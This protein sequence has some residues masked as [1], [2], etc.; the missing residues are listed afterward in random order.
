M[1][2]AVNELHAT[3][4]LLSIDD[5]IAL[6]AAQ[7]PK[8]GYDVVKTNPGVYAWVMENKAVLEQ[9]AKLG[10]MSAKVH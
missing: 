9:R 10:G 8:Q 5:G 4:R 6:I 1:T 7:I 2:P 3:L